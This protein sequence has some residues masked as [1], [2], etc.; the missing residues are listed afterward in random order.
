MSKDSLLKAVDL[1]GG[2]AP[3]A[4]GIRERLPGSKVG[5]VHIWGWLNSVKMEVPPA[6][7]VIAICGT[8]GWKITPHELRKDIYPNPADGLPDDRR[9]EAA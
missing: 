3:L 6:E 8:V 5:Q 9:K 7:V 2:Q 1:A 4:R